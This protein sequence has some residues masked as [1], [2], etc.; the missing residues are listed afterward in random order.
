M[1]RWLLLLLLLLF[2]AH[3]ARRAA[4]R[5]RPPPAGP[6]R[7]RPPVTAALVPCATCGVHFVAARGR[8]RGDSSYC[9]EACLKAA[10]APS[11]GAAEVPSRTAGGG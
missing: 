3:L 6:R 7:A 11:G 9:S 8:R 10:G 1:T 2:L 5:W 4:A